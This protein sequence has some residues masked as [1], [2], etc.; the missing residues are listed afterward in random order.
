MKWNHRIVL[1][2]DPDGDS[3]FA[4]QEVYYGRDG[5]PVGNCEP[6]VASESIGGLEETIKRFQEA[7][8]QPVLIS[9]NIGGAK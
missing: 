2:T 3:R 5:R 9:E 4:I 6:F 8:N 1:F 7:L